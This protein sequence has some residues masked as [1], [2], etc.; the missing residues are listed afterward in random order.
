MNESNWLEFALGM[1][2]SRVCLVL[3][4]QGSVLS[5]AVDIQ[6]LHNLLRIRNSYHSNSV[7]I[8]NFRNILFRFEFQL[9]NNELSHVSFGVQGFGLSLK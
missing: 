7:A 5:V 2:D 3:E 4:R 8:L 9:Q 6:D 1:V